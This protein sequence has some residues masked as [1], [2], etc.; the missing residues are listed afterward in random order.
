MKFLEGIMIQGDIL[1]KEQINTSVCKNCGYDRSMDFIQY[2]TVSQPKASD[3]SSYMDNT[4]SHINNKTYDDLYRSYIE[5]KYELATCYEKMGV[6]EKALK[7]FNELSIDDYYDSVERELFCKQKLNLNRSECLTKNI[8]PDGSWYEGELL[9]GRRHGK[10]KYYYKNGDW[11]EGEFKDNLRHGKGTQ[12]YISGDKYVGDWKYDYKSGKGSYYFINGDQYTG[13]FGGDHF[14]GKGKL[15]YKNG[16]VY[17][18]EFQA[19]RL[20]GEG[21]LCQKN[22]KKIQGVWANGNLLKQSFN[23][24]N[25]FKIQ[26]NS[27]HDDKQEKYE[28]ARQLEASGKYKE[29]INL[30]RDLED[31]RDSKLR[32]NACL[33]KEMQ[34]NPMFCV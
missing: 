7:L 22:G 2:R 20:H 13:G 17:D 9:N 34:K 15:Q 26:N 29:A 1:V 32:T 11:Y 28:K 3:L 14:Y 33:Y 5:I 30:Y 16:D 21:I 19:G 23:E 6:Y 18:G 8:Y 25:D 4:E 27:M 31:Y 10:G 12:H 24:K